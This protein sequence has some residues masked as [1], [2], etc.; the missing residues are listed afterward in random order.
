[1]TSD[2]QTY[3]LSLMVALE[4]A[5][6]LRQMPTCNQLAAYRGV[7]RGPRPPPGAEQP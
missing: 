6:A 1:M 3:S 5:A 7:G 2:Y 4:T